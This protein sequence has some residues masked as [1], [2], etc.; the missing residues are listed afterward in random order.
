ME[1]DRKFIEH[2]VFH[3]E[4]KNI[5]SKPLINQ[6]KKLIEKDKRNSIKILDASIAPNL[7]TY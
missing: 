1:L 6:I 2:I 7:I 4:N 5:N 3:L